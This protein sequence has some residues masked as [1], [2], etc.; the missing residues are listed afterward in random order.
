MAGEEDGKSVSRFEVGD[1]VRWCGSGLSWAGPVVGYSPDGYGV[2]VW[3]E[4]TSEPM[5]VGEHYLA[6]IPDDSDMTDV[7]CCKLTGDLQKK[8]WFKDRWNFSI[9]LEEM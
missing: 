7:Y 9:T 1:R 3:N 4:C 5:A 2:V 8:H 6:L